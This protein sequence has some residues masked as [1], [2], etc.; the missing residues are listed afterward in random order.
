MS[1]D[2]RSWAWRPSGL[3][4]RG[5]ILIIAAF[6]AWTQAARAS[7]GKLPVT[8]EAVHAGRWGFVIAAGAL[9]LGL[10]AALFAIGCLVWVVASTLSVLKWL[11]TS[12]ATGFKHGT[13]IEFGPNPWPPPLLLGDIFRGLLVGEDKRLSTSKTVST[14]W[15]YA[16]ASAM[17]SLVV[18]KWMGHGQALQS[19]IANGLQSQYGVLI[20]GPLGAAIMAKGIVSS[21]ITAGTAVKPPARSEGPTAAQLVSNDQA[22][23]DLGDLQY[24][25]FN[26]V[27]LLFFFGEFLRSPVSGLPVLPDLLVGLTTLS[28]IGYVGKKTLTSGAPT[29]T[30]VQPGSGKPGAL[31]RISGAGLVENGAEPTEIRFGSTTTT[32]AAALVEHGLVLEVNVPS[33]A[34]PGKVDLVVKTASGKYAKWDKQF[35]IVGP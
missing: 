1:E 29:I 34:S 6:F 10:P 9:V 4:T 32:V 27:A 12:V 22:Q 21:Q 28:A 35:D 16:V 30:D 2:G 7:Q 17:L 11:V 13:P 5:S 23:T 8:P 25:L 19:Q 3:R 20:G 31:V 33:D 26:V 15:T 14:V 18:A 24:V